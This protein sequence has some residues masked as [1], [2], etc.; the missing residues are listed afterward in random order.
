MEKLPGLW[1]GYKY[2]RDNLPNS[3]K[4]IKK[5]LE[6]EKINI[7]KNH[8]DGRRNSCDDEK[9]IITILLNHKLLKNRIIVQHKPRHWFDILVKDYRY[10]LLPIN[11]KSSKCKT[12]D[13]IGNM[14]SLVHSLTNINLIDDYLKFRPNGKMSKIYLKYT[15]DLKNMENKLLKKDY[16]FIIYNK[17][18]DEVYANSIR[19]LSNITSNINN[20]PFQVKWKGD[21]TSFKYNSIDNITKK[22]NKAIIQT[23]LTWTEEFLQEMRK[24]KITD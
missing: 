19:G 13:N 11:L 3:I 17:L 2:R 1:K 16:Y 15:K 6:K 20:L 10:G 18:N 5:I 8:D 21:N 14:S 22:I 24:I 4:L 7:S 9:S 23:K 12:A